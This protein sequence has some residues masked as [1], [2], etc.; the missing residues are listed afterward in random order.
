MMR[1][2]LLG[3]VAAVAMLVTG[4][5]LAAETT[6]TAPMTGGRTEL[7]QAG[8]QS[9]S[10][11]RVRVKSARLRARPDAKSPKVGASLRRGTRLQVLDSS[12]DWTHVRVGNREGYVLSSL[13]T[14]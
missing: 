6:E 10:N 2:D 13:L 4:A 3:A 7:A 1:R 9:M 11:A 12:G 5:A 14:M 8:Q